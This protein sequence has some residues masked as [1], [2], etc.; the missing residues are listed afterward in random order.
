M[1]RLGE[2]VPCTVLQGDPV[3]TFLHMLPPNLLSNAHA[4]WHIG[5]YRFTTSA[6]YVTKTQTQSIPHLEY[7]ERIN[8]SYSGFD[9]ACVG[10]GGKN[11][12]NPTKYARHNLAS[13]KSFIQLNAMLTGNKEHLALWIN[14]PHLYKT[15]M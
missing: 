11:I 9:G 14:E 7:A 1:I 5:C 3:R 8:P 6:Y 10:G 12:A 13:K 4:E 15:H 2:Y